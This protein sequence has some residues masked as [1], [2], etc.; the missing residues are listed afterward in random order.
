V[1]ISRLE[2]G[3]TEWSAEVLATVKEF[4]GIQ[5]HP[6]L[7]HEIRTYSDRLQVWK[8]LIIKGRF[9]EAKAMQEEMSIILD[10]PFE[11]DLYLLYL[12]SEAL[13]LGMEY[14]IPAAEEKLSFV[15]G[16]LEDANHDILD[17]YHLN[18]GFLCAY[19]GDLISSLKHSYKAVSHAEKAGKDA[20]VSA[21]INISH[22]YIFLGKPLQAIRYAERAKAHVRSDITMMTSAVI[23][24]NLG[25]CYSHVGEYRKA[26]ESLE[27]SI[28]QSKS[29]NANDLTGEVLTNKARLKLMMRMYEECINLC[30]QA[31]I[32]LENEHKGLY[33]G[34]LL[35][36]ADCLCEMKRY[37]ECRELLVC[38]RAMIEEGN[39][40]VLMEATNDDE[41]I[42]TINAISHLMTLDNSDSVSYIQD[43]AIPHFR[44]GG[45]SKFGALHYCDQLEAHFIKKRAKTKANAIAAISRDIYKEI[46]H[47]EIEFD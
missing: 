45:L 31:L 3:E 4:M 2:N 5:K 20:N 29:V 47:G 46:Y 10:L 28:A 37:D 34:T 14:N 41:R 18:K 17:L 8:T 38:A 1:A 26:S 7:E 22:T 15:E 35:T 25:T 24:N 11:H 39:S 30:D 44:A 42:I 27:L 6:L 19:A 32:Y 12:V 16:L 13:L 43:V 23:E 21:L 9:A 40:D 33:V 36:K